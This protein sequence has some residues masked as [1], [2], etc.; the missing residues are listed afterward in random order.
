MDSGIAH[1]LKGQFIST[2]K[3][4]LAM[5]GTATFTM[6][7][8]L[9]KVILADVDLG[10]NFPA[11]GGIINSRHNL[12]Q[13]TLSGTPGTMNPFRNDYGEVC[14]YCHTPHGAGIALQAPLWNRTNT[15]TSS[16][17]TY[18]TLGT[19]TLTG[20]VTTPG[21]ASLT[22]LSCHDGTVA[23]DSIINMPGSGPNT[24]SAAQET[25]FNDGFLDAWSSPY[26][27][28]AANNHMTLSDTGCLGCHSQSPSGLS[29]G[30]G[31]TDLTVQ[32]LGT[33]FTDDH[34]IGI[35]YKVGDPGFNVMNG[36]KGN[37]AFFD[38]DGNSRPDSGE[39]RAY[40]SGQGF[41]VE[42]ASCH[43]PH[44]VETGG[45]RFPTFLR[46]SNEASGVC[47]TCHIK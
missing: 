13:S 24:Y 42:C 3:L 12:T 29:L 6:L 30:S 10:T 2:R 11:G 18:N 23:V 16:Y 47:L 26:G 21:P 34:P 5:S 28:T 40:N 31:A 1:M 4:L 19:S 37:I 8:A 25:S 35:P 41:E 36:T 9:P 38:L 46:V 17:V 33:D 43:D 15:S 20:T 22:C 7:A 27:T 44:G 14:V 32:A 45:V 39:I